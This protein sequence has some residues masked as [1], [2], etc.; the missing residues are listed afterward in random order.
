M[1]SH[2]NVIE[3]S[4]SQQNELS[5]EI[6]LLLDLDDPLEELLNEFNDQDSEY[7]SDPFIET[8]KAQNYKLSFSDTTLHMTDT[9]IKQM[10]QIK[11]DIDRLSYYLDEM[12]ID[13]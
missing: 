3:V 2:E 1:S 11:D 6:E 10:S 12:N 13:N 5:E 7:S 8:G 4:F 9:L